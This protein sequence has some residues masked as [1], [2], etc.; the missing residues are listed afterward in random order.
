MHGN[1][2]SGFLLGGVVPQFDDR[3]QYRLPG[4]RTI[5]QVRLA[6]SPARN[7]AFRDS[8]TRTRLRTELRV[9]EANNRSRST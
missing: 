4:S 3:R 1:K 5:G 7:P 2:P 8:K 9:V 6:I